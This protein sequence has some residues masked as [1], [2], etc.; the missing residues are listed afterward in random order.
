ML[1]EAAEISTKFQLGKFQVEFDAVSPQDDQPNMGVHNA[2]QF[3][4]SYSSESSPGHIR[5][6]GSYQV[7]PD[8]MSFIKQAMWEGLGNICRSLTRNSTRG[9]GDPD[10]P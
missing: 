10:S 6:S 5:L 2:S 1:G 8:L 9:V 7:F 3:Y 4:S